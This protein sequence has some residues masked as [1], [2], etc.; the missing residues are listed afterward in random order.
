MSS[1]KVLILIIAKVDRWYLLRI[2]A[3][4][5]YEWRRKNPDR[6]PLII[7]REIDTIHNRRK[8][9]LQLHP[10]AHSFASGIMEIC[11]EGNLNAIFTVKDPEAPEVLKDST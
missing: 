5:C 7:I 3:E 6:R 8:D 2:F 1:L 9:P 10:E 11:H 4:A